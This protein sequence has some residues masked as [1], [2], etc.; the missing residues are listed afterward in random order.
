MGEAITG[1]S[2]IW[3]ASSKAAQ[4]VARF[5]LP[6][7]ELGAI[8]DWIDEDDERGCRERRTDKRGEMRRGGRCVPSYEVGW[9]QS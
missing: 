8:V 2:A 1:E 4:P 5:A 9:K 3:A 7:V 6:V